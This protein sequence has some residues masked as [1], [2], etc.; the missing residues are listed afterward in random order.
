MT[1]PIPVPVIN[2]NTEERRCGVVVVMRESK[3]IPVGRSS[4][5]IS[6]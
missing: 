5:P 2:M 4:E 3:K 6:G 1:M